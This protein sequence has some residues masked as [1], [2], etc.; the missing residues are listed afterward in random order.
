MR[1]TWWIRGL[2]FALFGMLA[3]GLVGAAVMLLWNALLPALF[4]LPTIG[5]WQAL[6]LLVLSRILVGG[7]RGRGR[8]RHWGGR[9]I[10]RWEQMSEEER[11]R[12]RAGMG[13]RC[14]RRGSEPTTEARV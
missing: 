9:M 5:F 4:G 12:F 11:E 3:I 14:G 6:G 13:R 1:K 7:L 8:H 10:A 2:K